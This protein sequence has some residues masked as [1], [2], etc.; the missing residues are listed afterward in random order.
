MSNEKQD[1]A[2]QCLN[3]IASESRRCGELVKNLLN[4]SRQAPMNVQPTDLNQVVKQCTMLLRHNLEIG[5]IQLHETLADGLPHLQ[6][7]PSQI[8]QVL[9]AVIVNAADAMPHGGNLWLETLLCSDARRLAITIRDDG[10]GIPPEVLPKIFEPFVTTK[11]HGHGTGLGLAV[12]RSI[13][14]RHSG[15][16]SVQSELGKGTTVTITLPVPASL[17]PGAEPVVAGV[18]KKKR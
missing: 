17:A 11:E 1:E 16:I 18:E 4:F 15:T 9:L 14:E 10:S 6:C 13:I 2:I 3:L 7:D 12:S 5:S 8:E